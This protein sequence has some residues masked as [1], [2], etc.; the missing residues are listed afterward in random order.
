MIWQET[1]FRQAPGVGPALTALKNRLFGMGEHYAMAARRVLTSHPTTL[2]RYPELV[3]EMSIRGAGE[4]YGFTGK[5][6]RQEILDCMVCDGSS[7]DGFPPD[8]RAWVE[9]DAD[10]KDVKAAEKQLRNNEEL[11]LRLR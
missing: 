6:S 10:S 8:W 9:D 4:S 7:M 2:S 1:H 5:P 3:Q 11:W